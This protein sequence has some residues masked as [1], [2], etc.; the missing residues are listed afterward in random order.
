MLAANL[1]KT[2]ELTVA[3]IRQSE[4]SHPVQSFVAPI[5][6]RNSLNFD[7]SNRRNLGPATLWPLADG[8]EHFISSRGF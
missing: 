1:F 4:P 7:T 3:L 8:F 5:L 6:D 2:R